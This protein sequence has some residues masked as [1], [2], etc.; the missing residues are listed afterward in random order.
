MRN[1]Q[2]IGRGLYLEDIGRGPVMEDIFSDIRK[3]SF[4]AAEHLDPNGQICVEFVTL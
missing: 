4:Y 2:D 1:R 3:F